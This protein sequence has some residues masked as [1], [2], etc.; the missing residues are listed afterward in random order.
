MRGAAASAG[1]LLAGLA[2]AGL[3][4]A[5]PALAGD[6]LVSVGE[7]PDAAGEV[8]VAA[9]PPARFPNGPCPFLGRVKA[10]AGTVVVRLVGVP[11]GRWGI[12]AFQD[13]NGDGVLGKDWLGRPTEPA[14]FG[15]D[16][17]MTRFGPPE[18]ATAAVEMPAAGDGQTSLRLRVR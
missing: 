13:R 11:A 4:P 7:V 8:L 5:G 10:Q 16:A 17:P 3:A 18:H 15:N 2:L 6:M 1:L 12:A 14:G 9:C